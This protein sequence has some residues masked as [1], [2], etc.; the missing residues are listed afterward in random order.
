MV[1]RGDITIWLTPEAVA[2]WRAT[3][4][5]KRGGQRRYSDLAIET[6]LTLRLVFHLPLRQTEGFLG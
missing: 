2:A 5:G 1:Q 4:N 3:R 6:A